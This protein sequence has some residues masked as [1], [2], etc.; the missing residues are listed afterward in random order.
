MKK[1]STEVHLSREMGL[2]D[3]ALIGFG[4]F[5]LTL[6]VSAIL[7]IVESRESLKKF[8]SRDRKDLP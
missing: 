6:S 8:F 4:A 1:F 5:L 3:A 7:L 2:W